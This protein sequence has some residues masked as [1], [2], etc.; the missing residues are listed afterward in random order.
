MTG[1]PLP[2]GRSIGQIIQYAYTVADIDRSMALYTERFGVGPWFRRG[3]FTPPNARYRGESTGLT[4]SLAR[5]FVGDTMIELIQQ[6]D[7]GPSV[8]RKVIEQG[9]GFHHWAVGVDDV[10]ERIAYF[11]A[12]GY[13]AVF[14]DVLTALGT[15]ALRDVPVSFTRF[16][17]GIQAIAAGT[18]A[19]CPVYDDPAAVVPRGRGAVHPGVTSAVE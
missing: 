4:I 7:D 11:A 5:A 12:L 18:V 10:E 13:P 17:A 6:H 9:H 1:A 14:E 3:P 15:G 2:F 8:Y 16:G 19:L